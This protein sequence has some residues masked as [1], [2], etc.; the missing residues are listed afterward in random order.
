[1][2]SESQTASP[3]KQTEHLW[4]D[5]VPGEKVLPLVDSRKV[6]GSFGM[7]ES[8]AS[9][10][11]A[12]PLHTHL[13]TEIF[14]VLSGKMTFQV[15]EHIFEAKAGEVAVV[16]AGEAHSWRNRSD[17]DVRTIVTFVPGGI[18]QIFTRIAGLGPLELAAIAEQYGSKFVGPPLPE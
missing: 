5:T 18:D 16:R 8:V 4:Y 17:S 15:G 12:T 7:M 14:Y 11:A 3:S 9:P 6:G 2:Q 13:E 1:M 10:G